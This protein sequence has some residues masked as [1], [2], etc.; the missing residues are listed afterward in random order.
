MERQTTSCYKLPSS[1]SPKKYQRSTP[2]RGGERKNNTRREIH[3]ARKGGRR[4][5]QVG[6][7][8]AAWPP[9]FVEHE[10]QKSGENKQKHKKKRESTSAF[11]GE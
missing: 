8:L 9:M 10:S 7:N 5:K 3:I 11:P 6:I 4:G 1:S 2:V